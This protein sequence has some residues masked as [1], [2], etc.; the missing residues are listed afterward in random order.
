MKAFISHSSAQKDFADVIVDKLGR[1]QCILDKYD[2]EPAYTS[3]SQIVNGI[4]RSEVLV[5]LVTKE[6]LASDWCRNEISLAKEALREQR[7]R[8]FIPYIIDPEITLEDIPVWM[9]KTK[10]F[11]MK[12]FRSPILLARDIDKKIRELEWEDMPMLRREDEIFVGRNSEINEFQTKKARKRHACCLLVSGRAGSGRHYF[13]TKCA[14]GLDRKRLSLT[15]RV[16]LSLDE[17]LED[18]L[19]QLNA[20]TCLYNND[21]LSDILTAEESVKI[22]AAAELMNEIYRYQGRIEISDHRVIVNDIGRVSDWFEKILNHRKLD[23]KLGT[24]VISSINPRAYEEDN[25]EPLITVSLGDLTDDDRNVIFTSYLD[26]YGVDDI[27]DED[28]DFFV[29]MLLQSPSQL[30]QIARIIKERGVGEARRCAGAIRDKGDSL[31]SELIADYSE[32][33][34][35]IQFLLLLSEME[36]AGYDDLKIIYGDEFKKIEKKLHDLIQRSIIFEFGPSSSLLR[37]D[38]AVADYLL[39]GKTKLCANLRKKL[40][41]YVKG[42]VDENVTLTD[43]PTKY[44]IKCKD[45]IDR[46]DFKMEKLLIPSIALKA[47][48]RMYRRGTTAGYEATA[49]LCLEVLKKAHAVNLMDEVKLDIKFYLCLSF[50]HLGREKEFFFHVKDFQGIR[51]DFLH[52]FW[53]RQNH[54]Y[55]KAKEYY[56]NVLNVS[57]MRKARNEYIIVLTLLKRYD[58]ARKYASAQFEEDPDNPYYITSYFKCVS[59][60]KEREAE[61]ADL[62]ET[63]ISRMSKSIVKDREQYVDAMKLLRMVRDMSFSRTE[64]YNRIEALQRQYPDINSYLKDAIEICRN[65]LSK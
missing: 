30:R 56:E 37:V 40:D 23:R 7:L 16:S 6:S 20:T 24:I 39:R 35:V 29:N 12:Y 48:I 15:E 65:R 45:L 54:N 1:D 13:A 36:I 44:M 61:D 4:N 3:L 42:V 59:L 8:L 63:L 9:S 19:I 11:N 32:N 34:T 46:G 14:N 51:R 25:I 64:K 21:Y 43:D 60:C 10:C 62:M 2:F 52:G 22:E 18:F 58:E 49:N 57:R 47:I 5:F 26:E 28:I 41:S 31:V 27:S 50:A 55:Q 38:T 33:K 17:G 53:F